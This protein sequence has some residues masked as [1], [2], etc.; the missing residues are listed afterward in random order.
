MVPDGVPQVGCVLLVAEGIEGG[1]GMAFITTLTEVGD[2][3]LNELVTVK[4]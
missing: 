4:V 1:V 3:Q 2:V